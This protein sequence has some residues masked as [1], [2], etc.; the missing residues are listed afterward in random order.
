MTTARE[1]IEDALRIC[2]GTGDEEPIEPADSQRAIRVLNDMM[3]AFEESEEI[4]LGYTVVT[5]LTDVLTTDAGATRGMKSML[6]LELWPYYS[7]QDP[8]SL[9]AGRA[10]SGKRDLLNLGL[11][12]EDAEFPDSLPLGSGNTGM[13]RYCGDTFFPLNEE[14]DD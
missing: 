11:E 8:P 7:R 6:G 13:N 12:I 5:G 9:I 10:R 3:A 2:F 4:D 14:D 1:V